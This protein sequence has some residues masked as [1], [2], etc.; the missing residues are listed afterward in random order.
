MEAN[1]HPQ[2]LERTCVQAGR[3]SSRRAMFLSLAYRGAN[4]SLVGVRLRWFCLYRGVRGLDD[5]SALSNRM[6]E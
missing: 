2:V 5:I 1:K 3:R 4:L 6:A